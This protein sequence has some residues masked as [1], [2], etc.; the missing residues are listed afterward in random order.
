MIIQDIERGE[1][2]CLIDPLGTTAEKVIDYIPRW[3][4]NDFRYFNV[5]DTERPLGLNVLSGGN[6]DAITA[7]ISAFAAL[8]GLSREQ[9]PQLLSILGYA[10]AALREV[11]NATLLHLPRLLT[12]DGYRERVLERVTDPGVRS[13]WLTDFGSRGARERR[14]ASSAVLNKVQE[15]R[16]DAILRN[17]FGQE[18]NAIDPP[19][20]MAR[21]RILIV[22]L[23]A[24]QIGKENARLIGAFLV[25]FFERAAAARMMAIERRER[26]DRAGLARG[27]PRFLSVRRRVPGFR[28][29]QFRRR[30]FAEPQRPAVVRLL[31][32]VPRSDPGEGAPGGFR[33]RRLAV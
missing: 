4:T 23:A 2:V 33:Q 3:R 29:H 28:D 20:L 32:S 30:A 19:F 17:I 31:P 7:T 18:Q 14:E 21:R 16:R 1:G 5:A 6:P 12:D 13:Y 25:S 27:V 9:T 11:P 22:N 24:S 26:E 15:L 8:W 10:L